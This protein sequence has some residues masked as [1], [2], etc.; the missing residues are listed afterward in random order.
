MSIYN[1]PERVC[2]SGTLEDW[3]QFIGAQVLGH[4]NL[5]LAL[6]LSVTAPV[7][8]L[9]KE[10]GTLSDYPIWALIGDSS[11]GKTT[12]LKL[13]ASVWGSPDENNGLLFD[14]HA[15]ENAIYK[16][17]A[18]NQGVPVLL[19]ETS[20]VPD[21]S[22]DNFLYNLPK[23]HGKLRCDSKG[24]LRDTDHF[25][26]AVIFTGEQS[27]FLQTKMNDGIFARLLEFTLPWTE[28]AAHAHA[29]E[30]G[31]RKFHGTAAE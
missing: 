26:G 7:S 21:W 20:S 6:A 31:S 24:D 14:L 11:T 3:L 4:D 27:L 30:K 15:T 29:V 8:Y 13:I 12:S 28:S 2:P 10:A 23:G 16:L 9:L 19:D 22:F 18:K 1:E 5:E 17:M 25:A